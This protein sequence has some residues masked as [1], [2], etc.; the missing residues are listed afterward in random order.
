MHH[1]IAQTKQFLKALSSLVSGASAEVYLSVPFTA[2]AAAAELSDGSIQIG[3]QNM[4]DAEQGAFTGEVS[5]TMLKEVGATF[6]LLG[7]SERRHVFG[8]ADSLINKKVHT[9]LQHGIEPIFCCG[10]TLEQREAGETEQVLKQQLAEGLKG[11]TAEQMARVVVAYEPVWAIGTGKTATV[12]QLQ[13]TH[14]AIRQQVRQQWGDQVADQ[15]VIQY[16]GSVKPE[17]AAEIVN[18]AD[19][20]GVLVGGAS[21]DPESFAAIVASYQ[22]SKIRHG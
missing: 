5:A 14:A 1:T 17:N 6:V 10:E 4:H 8:E 11:V 7:H 15:L 12:E 3:A 9:A 22:P 19:V 2:I 16:G 18:Q 20:D 21:L 13:Q